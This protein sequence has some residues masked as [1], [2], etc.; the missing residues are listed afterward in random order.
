MARPAPPAAALP[1]RAGE[2]LYNAVAGMSAAAWQDPGALDAT[3]A[4]AE[5]L[6][7]ALHG[8]GGLG[9]YTQLLTGGGGSAGP[10]TSVWVA[11]TIAYRWADW[12]GGRRNN[13]C[14]AGAT[15]WL[16]LLQASRRIA[17]PPAAGAARAAC[18]PRPPSAWTA[19]G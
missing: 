1:P 17:N 12:A 13:H 6:L 8:C 7:C 10:C 16:L 2:A 19:S 11:G 4:R 3:L 14:T 15:S 9:A 18:R 5:A